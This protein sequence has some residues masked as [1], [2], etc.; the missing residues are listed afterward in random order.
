M[1]TIAMCALAVFLFAATGNAQTQSAPAQTAPAK[2]SPLKTDLDRIS[3]SIGMNL[4]SGLKEQAIQINTEILIRG[5]KDAMSGTKPLMTD[6]EIRASLD[7]L[8]GQLQAKHA[9]MQEKLSGE[10]KMKGEKFLAEN[11]AKE[12]VVTLPSGLQYK[13][14]KQGAGPKPTATDT[15]TTHYRGT[16]IDG[17]Q[18]D[19]S[20]DRKEP[21]TFPVSGVI[22]GWTEA[23]QLMPV[24]SKWQ[25][26]IPSSLAYGDRGAANVIGPN[27]TLIF[28]VELLSIQEPQKK[29]P[30]KK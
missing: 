21:A 20:Y 24:G 23:L 7:A 8:K 22:K 30:E 1:K 5:I 10:N 2:Q 16:L 27:E 9:A 6:D 18:F 25:L 13:V 12:G 17:T 19:S 15:V 26:F 29:E 11:K 28:D 14:L 3:Y 4:G